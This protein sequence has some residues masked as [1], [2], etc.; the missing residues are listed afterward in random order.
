MK[1]I[2][3]TGGTVFVSRYVA[4]YCATRG[5][6][7]FVLNRGIKTQPPGVSLIKCDRHSIGDKL[8]NI[9]FDAVV[10]VTAYDA[11]DI[12]DL[13]GALGDC[14]AHVMI[15]SSAVYPETGAQPFREES[16]LGPN[17]FWGEYGVGKILAERELQE[18]FPGA[19]ILRPPYLY[20][21]MN[22]VYREAFVFEC[23]EKKRPFFLP[24]DGAMRLQFFHVRDLCRFIDVVLEKRPER[25]VFNVGNNDPITVKD[26][27]ALCYRIVGRKPEYVGVHEDV[28]Q[29]NYFS[30]YD[31][32]YRLDVENQRAMMPETTSLEDGLERAYAWYRGNREKVGVKPFI[33]YIDENFGRIP[34]L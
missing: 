20:G 6:E 29:R 10:D 5:H 19:Y 11:R 30:F 12:V 27:A 1:K 4:E 31:Y 3:V 33:A 23:A 24:K 25:H 26:W 16:P 22:N 13:T 9:R 17:K 21:E 7:V 15:S 32:E 8:R 14:G 34:K 18:R 28:E 2:L